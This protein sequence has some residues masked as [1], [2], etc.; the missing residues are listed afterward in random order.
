MM[1]LAIKAEKLRKTILIILFQYYLLEV[2]LGGRVNAISS[3]L[4]CRCFIV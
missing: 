2:D 4:T 3:T 1:D